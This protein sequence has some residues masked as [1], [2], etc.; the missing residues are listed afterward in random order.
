[1][2]PDRQLVDRQCNFEDA[3]F[4]SAMVEAFDKMMKARKVAGCSGF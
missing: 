4:A 1:V 2:K 3:P